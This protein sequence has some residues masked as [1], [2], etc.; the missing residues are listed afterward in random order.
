MA[1]PD[2]TG[3]DVVMVL[4]VLALLRL[5]S[6]PPPDDTAAQD[7]FRAL[8]ADPVRVNGTL[9]TA[10]DLVARARVLQAALADP[11]R[12]VLEHVEA[13]SKVT[14]AFQLRGLHVGPLTTS[15]GT[16]PPTGRTLTLR[17]VDVLTMADGRITEIVMVADELGALAGVG[18]VQLVG[19]GATG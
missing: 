11:E 1:D 8:Y 13:G 6:E 16:V 2:A 19:D 12:T 5:W 7:A 4:D 9:L 10:A 17:V 3:H 18:A 14:V 15:L